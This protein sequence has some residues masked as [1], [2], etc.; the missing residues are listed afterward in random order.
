MSLGHP[1]PTLELTSEERRELSGFAASRS[2]PHSLVARAQLVLWSA[3]GVANAEIGENIDTAATVIAAI[4]KVLSL[5]PD[6]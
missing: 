3:E 6:L 2:L 5:Y 1:L 4:T